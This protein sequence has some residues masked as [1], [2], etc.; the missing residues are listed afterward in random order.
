MNNAWFGL[1]GVVIGVAATG[2]KEWLATFLYRQKRANYLAIR[3]ITILDTF[4]VRCNSV[5]YDDGTHHGQP[6]QDGFHR[7]QV[8][9]P[10]F[11]PLSF[12]VDWKSIPSNLMYEILIFPSK[13]ESSRRI[14]CVID[15]HDYDPP[16]FPEYFEERQYQ[17]SLLGI[18]AF[19][20]IERL[21]EN[22][23]IPLNSYHNFNPIESLNEKIKKIE[24]RRRVFEERY[25]SES[26]SLI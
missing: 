17:Y 14:I 20:I 2:L 8:E 22:R 4:I 21:R 12:D 15:E 3:V 18:K 25:N 26:N 13:I 24:D 1:I 7:P 11:D 9:L 10:E 23:K 16:E 6:D 19:E 5:A